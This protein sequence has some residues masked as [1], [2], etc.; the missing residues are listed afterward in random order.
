MHARSAWQGWCARRERV[1]GRGCAAHRWAART[2]AGLGTDARFACGAC[3]W[4]G[5]RPAERRISASSRAHVLPAHF[6]RCVLELLAQPSAHRRPWTAGRRRRDARTLKGTGFACG[7]ASRGVDA[8][9]A[10][11]RRADPDARFACRRTGPA[12]PTLPCPPTPRTKGELGGADMHKGCGCPARQRGCILAGHPPARSQSQ[13]HTPSQAHRARSAR[14]LSKA[15]MRGGRRVG[16]GPSAGGGGRGCG[17]SRLQ[18]GM[19]ALRARPARANPSPT[20]PT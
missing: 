12:R 1:G 6:A 9:F 20:P 11:R 14:C 16:G 19:G 17:G 8:R 2:D 7:R 15:A 10:C 13:S 18:S 4:A 3:W 5:E